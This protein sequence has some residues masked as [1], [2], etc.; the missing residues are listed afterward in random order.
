MLFLARL[1]HGFGQSDSVKNPIKIPSGCNCICYTHIYIYEGCKVVMQE[2]KLDELLD[3]LFDPG[4]GGRPQDVPT[5]E[6]QQ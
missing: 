2:L 6:Q 1:S 4:W 5:Q 3:G